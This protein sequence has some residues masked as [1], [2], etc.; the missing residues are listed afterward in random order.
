MLRKNTIA[1]LTAIALVGAV[2]VGVKTTRTNS[3]NEVQLTADHAKV[4][5]VVQSINNQESIKQLTEIIQNMKM[6]IK[7]LEAAWND[8]SVQLK[9]ISLELQATKTVAE[10]LNKNATRPF[11]NEVPVRFDEQLSQDRKMDAQQPAINEPMLTAI[12]IEREKQYFL[13]LDQSLGLQQIDTAWS[14][15]MQQQFLKLEQ[16]FSALQLSGT[17]MATS[18]CRTN[19]CKVEWVHADNDEQQLAT[20]LLAIKG[21]SG[22]SLQYI[23]GNNNQRPRTIAYFER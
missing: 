2:A 15:A 19:L 8:Q 17:L 5:H 18:D 23:D 11:E 9:Q 3:I 16:R 21:T 14:Q 1:Y 10:S 20:N 12:E 7:Q 6:H 13:D 22:V 4:K